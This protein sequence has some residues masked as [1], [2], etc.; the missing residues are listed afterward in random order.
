MTRRGMSTFISYKI[1]GLPRALI[2][3]SPLP[4]VISRST[5]YLK[6]NSTFLRTQS[7]V[8]GH[9]SSS[10]LSSIQ[11]LPRKSLLCYRQYTLSTQ[12]AKFSDSGKRELA[13]GNVT[14][15]STEAPVE[16]FQPAEGVNGKKDARVNNWET[17]GPAAF[18]F[19]SMLYHFVSDSFGSVELWKASVFR[20]VSSFLALYGI[21]IYNQCCHSPQHDKPSTPSPPSPFTSPPDPTAKTTPTNHLQAIPP[22]PRP[23]QCYTP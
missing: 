7:I 21:R 6:S 4:E 9:T 16:T 13:K 20:I 11:L 8:S 23:S 22:H 12:V 10:F 1:G 14:M 2:V 5:C 3:T 15:G 19:R 18:D 17:P